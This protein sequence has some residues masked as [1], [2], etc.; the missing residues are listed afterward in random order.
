MSL[1]QPPEEETRTNFRNVVYD[2]SNS[3]VLPKKLQVPPLSKEF[4]IFYGIR[5]F[6]TVFTTARHL[7][8][9]WKIHT[10]YTV[11]KAKF[12]LEQSMKTQRGHSST[13]SLTSALNMGGWLTPRPGS[14]TPGNRTRYPLYRR[15][16]G[17]QG[18]SGRVRKILPPPG[19]DPRTNWLCPRN[20]P[21]IVT[22]IQK[23][24]SS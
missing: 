20:E 7:F 12:T 5:L 13:L 6:I 21:Y 19:F 4:L 11:K 23:G 10:K 2:L 24:T 3:T 17:P 9:F 15:R 18:R 16:G 14:F 1:W 22:S 8:L